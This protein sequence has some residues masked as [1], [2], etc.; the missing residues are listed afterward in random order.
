MVSKPVVLPNGKSW[1]SQGDAQNHFL[2]MRLRHQ[3]N[4]P[5]ADPADHADLLALLERYDEAINEGPSKIGAGVAHF[6]TRM[7]RT[8]GGRNIGFWV[9]RINNSETDFSIFKAVAARAS[10]KAQQF[11]DACRVAIADD[12]NAAKK[13][14]F[15]TWGDAGGT[16]ECEATGMRIGRFEARN[17]YVIMPFRDIVHG[18]RVAQGWDERLPDDIITKPNDAQTITTFQDPVAAEAFRRYHH[19]VAQIRLVAKD[20]PASQVSA[21]R[22]RRAARPLSLS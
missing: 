5:I 8:N 14:H 1:A 11:S 17:D 15:D 2:D 21:S 9:I 6:E 20:A 19:S 18:F 4:T 12:L 22:S 10:T 16:I 7:N 13:V 3:L